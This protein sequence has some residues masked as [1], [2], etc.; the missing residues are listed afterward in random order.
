MSEEIKLKQLRIIRHAEL[1]A[2][3]WTQG[4][5]SQLSSAKKQEWLTYRQTLR[6]F[7]ST[8]NLDEITYNQDMHIIEN[9]EW[10][11]KPS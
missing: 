11:T 8:I 5:D 7:P 3:D 1:S 9:V 6:D 2:C 10:P 4:N